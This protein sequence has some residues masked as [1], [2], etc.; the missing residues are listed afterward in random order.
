MKIGSIIQ[1]AKLVK[2]IFKLMGLGVTRAETLEANTKTK[3]HLEIQVQCS[4]F[5]STTY[6]FGQFKLNPFL[7]F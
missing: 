7:C 3:L 4:A 2:V 1:L 6:T 5:I